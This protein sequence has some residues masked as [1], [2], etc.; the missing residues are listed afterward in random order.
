MT[1]AAPSPLEAWAN[2]YV[3]LGSSAAALTGLQFVVLTLIAQANRVSSSSGE[4]LAAF[5]SPNVVHFC[6]ALLVS[7]TLSAPWPSLAGAGVSVAIFGAAGLL[8]SGL[9]IRRAH[10]QT[11]Y[12]PVFEDWLWH[13]ILPPLAYTA[14]MASGILLA[15]RPQGALFASAGAVVL[16]VSIGIH[17]AWDTVTYVTLEQIRRER[18]AR[19]RSAAPAPPRSDPASGEEPKKSS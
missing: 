10:R 7:C 6:A 11:E 5:G 17:N 14:I 19:E 3:I 12:Q 1:R 2:F 16:L 4:S 18:A 8:Y 9:V 15:R 13:T